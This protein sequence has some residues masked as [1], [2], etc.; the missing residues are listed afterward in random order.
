M[1]RTHH[2]KL[3]LPENLASQPRRGVE[4]VIAN[5]GSRDDL[6]EWIR[7][8]FR[9]ELRAGRIRY[10][11]NRRPRYFHQS[12]A[13]NLAHR[14]AQGD[15]VCNLDADNIAGRGLTDHLR[16]VFSREPDSLVHFTGNYSAHGRI[17]LLRH[18]FDEL[19]GYDEN[20]SGWGLEDYEFVHRACALRHLTLARCGLPQFAGC[21]DHSDEAR[22]ENMSPRLARL[23]K[24]GMRDANERRMRYRSPE[25]KRGALIPRLIH[26]LVLD[27][28]TDFACQANRRTWRRWHPGWE[29][30]DWTETE[31]VNRFG[32]APGEWC[33]ESRRAWLHC[34][35][36]YELGGVVIHP[37]LRCGQ[38]I[39]GL[40]RDT[41]AAYFPGDGDS[42]FWLGAGFRRHSLPWELS[43]E[44]RVFP[45]DDRASAFLR[46]A[47]RHHWREIK[48]DP[49]RPRG[50]TQSSRT[51]W[52]P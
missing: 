30:R 49:E 27:G 40:L 23:G 21:L 24:Q 46:I 17:A 32:P 42:M 37:R 38:P 16:D 25:W 26:F 31:A 8:T 44:H 12:K 45:L 39:D 10:V 47:R 6:D 20:F 43:R 35:L 34:R 3:T 22:M 19:G 4:F 15:I 52:L 29:F 9:E 41:S 50:R 48:P 36:L 5:Y 7:S 14:S 51:L 1:N 11:R 33:G 13:K 2:L 28:D 18:H